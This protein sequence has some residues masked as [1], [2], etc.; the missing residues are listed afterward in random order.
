MLERDMACV[1]RDGT[2]LRANVYHSA[3]EQRLPTLVC[4]TA[5][6]KNRSIYTELAERLASSGY[7]V[8]V[9]DH[10]GRHKSDGEYH[11]MFAPASEGSDVADG[12]DTIEWAARLPWSDGRVGAWGHSY[13]GWSV[14]MMLAAQPPSLRAALASGISPNLLSL[15]FGIFET[16]RRLEWTY[17][18]AAVDPRPR[19]AGRPPLPRDEASRRWQEVERGKYLWWLPLADI[20]PDVFPGLNEALHEFH[21]SQHVDAWDFTEVYPL[22]DI[23]VMQ[24]TG[25][26]DR[27]IGTVDNF[28]GLAPGEQDSAPESQ[29]R[30]VVGPWGH[31]SSELAGD[32]GP[33]DYG[34]EATRPYGDMVQRWFDFQLKGLDNGLADEAPVQLF[35]P[36]ENKWRDEAR[37]P[38]ARAERLDLYLHSGGA[39]NSVAGDGS[40]AAA[41]PNAPEKSLR[42]A[43]LGLEHGRSGAP[44]DEFDYDPRDP[45]MSL[46]RSDSQAIPIDQSPHDGRQDVLVYDTGPL[47]NELELVGPVELRLW[48]STDGPDTDWTARLAVVDADNFAVN[49]T[50]GIL[51]TQYR[52]GHGKPQLLTPGKVYEYTVK[53]NPIGVRLMPGQRLRLYLSSSDFPNFDRNHNTGKPYWS[54]AELRTAHQTIFHSPEMPSHLV[55]PMVPL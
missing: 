46:F 54:D 9:Q 53:L 33:I 2:T 19:S 36:G 1:M 30:L 25:W 17:S 23:P 39:A 27:L 51:R 34:A 11:W 4:R 35:V 28:S 37:W 32:I 29:H 41:P 7:T 49:L 21:R 50:Y 31:D 44:H 12:Y 26:W 45:V 24:I 20:P 43:D 13:D 10:R 55:L 14:W 38:L 22:V 40:L 52:H 15:T 3:H 8:V 16:G 42:R 6:D 5:Y 48:A 18:M 47:H